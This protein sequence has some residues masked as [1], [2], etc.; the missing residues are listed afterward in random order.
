MNEEYWNKLI[1]DLFLAF[2]IKELYGL[3]YIGSK[4]NVR[5]FDINYTTNE[6]PDLIQVGVV[7]DKGE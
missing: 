7:E 2:D 3:E 1:R 6:H 5:R 4:D